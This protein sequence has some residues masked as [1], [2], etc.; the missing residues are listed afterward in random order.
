M[1]SQERVLIR[2]IPSSSG[3]LARKCRVNRAHTRAADGIMGQRA[4]N[5]SPFKESLSGREA[6]SIV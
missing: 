3:F 2:A 6:Q 1:T 5:L 4:S